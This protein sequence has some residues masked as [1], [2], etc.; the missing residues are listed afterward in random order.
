[1]KNAPGN[2]SKYSVVN[3]EDMKCTEKF[4]IIENENM[5][6]YSFEDVLKFLIY[7]GQ[8]HGWKTFGQ[9]VQGFNLR[10]DYFVYNLQTPF[11]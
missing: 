10:A 4:W 2:F 11:F 9:A 7:A 5:T 3:K 6:N 8:G 1:M